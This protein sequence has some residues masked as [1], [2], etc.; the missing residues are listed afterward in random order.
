MNKKTFTN[1]DF[2]YNLFI[3]LQMYKIKL[4]TK[5]FS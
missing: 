3:K 4:K 1:I 2:V 5:P